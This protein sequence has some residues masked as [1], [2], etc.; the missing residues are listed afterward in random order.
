MRNY[1]INPESRVNYTGKRL[2]VESGVNKRRCLVDGSNT[3]AIGFRTSLTGKNAM[4]YSA[5]EGG[6]LRNICPRLSSGENSI[7]QTAISRI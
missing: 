1:V 6:F 3:K 5:D 4:T 2:R 7:F